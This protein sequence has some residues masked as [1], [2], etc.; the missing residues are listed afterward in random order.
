MPMTENT[1][2][3]E[4]EVGLETFNEYSNDMEFIAFT[5]DDEW[6]IVRVSPRFYRDHYGI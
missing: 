3:V 2:Y 6:V 1:R 4:I 5:A